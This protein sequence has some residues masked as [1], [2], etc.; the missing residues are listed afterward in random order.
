[1]EVVFWI[2]KWVIWQWLLIKNIHKLNAFR[3]TSFVLLLIINPHRM[4][5]YWKVIVPLHPSNP[6]LKISF[7]GN[8]VLCFLHLW[9]VAKSS[10]SHLVLEKKKKSV[11]C[12]EL[13][14]SLWYNF[15]KAEVG[16]HLKEFCA[17][18]MKWILHLSY[19]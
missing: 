1:M 8:L 13:C 11:I 15:Y 3:T 12:M 14:M 16:V 18:E 17:Y 6:V 4:W 9:R 10:F 5:L 7:L 19:Y 2:W